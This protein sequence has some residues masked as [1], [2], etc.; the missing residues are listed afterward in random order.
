M[1]THNI[2]HISFWKLIKDFP[3]TFN[4]KVGD[5]FIFDSEYKTIK[6]HDNKIHFCDFN[7]EMYP[8]FFESVNF[9]TPKSEDD[10]ALL[11]DNVIKINRLNKSGQAKVLNFLYHFIYRDDAKLASIMSNIPWL[12]EDEILENDQETMHL[13]LKKIKLI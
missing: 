12:I 6:T 4:L 9:P 3:N 10:F 7:P 1:N 11:L 5:S 8:E 13:T 2:Q